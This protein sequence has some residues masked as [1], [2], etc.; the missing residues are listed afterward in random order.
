M[1]NRSEIRDFLISRRARITPEQAGL[2]PDLTVRRVPGLRRG[3]AADLA[4]IS[5]E[6][7]VRMERG[8][9]RG[10]S[11]AVLDAVARALNLDE[12]ERAHFNDTNTPSAALPRE[13]EKP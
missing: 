2:R 5:I 9:L 7:Y 6:Y 4:G 3:E 13:L 8:N 12:A 10:V 11:Q 1:D